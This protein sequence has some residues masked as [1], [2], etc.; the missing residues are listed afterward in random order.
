MAVSFVTGK[1]TQCAGK[2]EYLKESKMW[3][4]LYC[5]ALAQREETYDGLF[6]IKN[7]VRQSLLDTAYQR[8]DSAQKNLVECEKIDSRYVGTLIAKIAYEMVC[9]SSPGACNP[10]NQKNM[11]SQLGRHYDQLKSISTDVLDD[12]AVL[13]EFLEESDIFATLMSVYDTLGDTARRDYVAQFLDVK[14]IYSKSANN[15]LLTYSIKKGKFEI[16]DQVLNNTDNLDIIGALN[17][18][19][20]KYPDNE[21][22]AF[23]VKKLFATGEIKTEHKA[24]IENYLSSSE[25][26]VETKSD[27]LVDALNSQIKIN[28]DVI[29]SVLSKAQAPQ[30]QQVLN[31]LCI[32]RLS[33]MEVFSILNYAYTGGNFE[34]AKVTF[35]CL[36]DSGQYV[37]PP[38]KDVI[39]MLCDKNYSAQQKVE[40]LELT[41]EFKMERKALEAILSNYLCYSTDDVDARK[42]VIDFLFASVSDCPTQTAETYVLKCSADGQ[43]KPDVIRQMFTNKLNVLFVG[44]LL[45]EYMN[46]SCDEQDI[47]IE[48]IDTMVQL[49]MNINPTTLTE[50]VCYSKDSVQTKINFIQKMVRNGTQIRADMACVYL[51]NVKPDDF[52]SELLSAIFNPSGTFSQK[53]IENYVLY[54]R[55]REAIKAQNVRVI[56]DMSPGADLGMGLGKSCRITHLGNSIC[57]NLLQAYTLLTT[58]STAVALEVA[59]VL[60]NSLRLK[61][62]DEINV[63]GANMKMKKYV[64]ANRQSLGLTTD[65]ICEKFRVYSM[66]F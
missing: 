40:L 39:S 10:S 4:C 50:Y 7:V 66:I 42:M 13:Y 36:K 22:K 27:I 65:A 49:G 62:N 23:N 32:N 28:V 1:C 51:E 57:C 29:T 38:A 59:N 24:M 9:L 12:E 19:L 60:A 64:V 56:L 41:F 53:A 31:Q 17:D 15:N 8:F 54:F 6:T 55:E 3:R 61:I 35:K 34:N 48:V 26:S 16:T 52:S 46:S 11:F 25:N 14:N 45:S 20:N 5:G 2:L 18:V 30:V 63:S 43:R 21:S 47:K 58:D 33:D 44:D 37:I